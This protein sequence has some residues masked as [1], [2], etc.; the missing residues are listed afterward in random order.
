MTRASYTEGFNRLKQ[1]VRQIAFWVSIAV[2]VFRFGYGNGNYGSYDRWP[3]VT[4]F[5]RDD[6]VLLFI[7]CTLGISIFRRLCTFPIT[8]VEYV[9][10]GF[11]QFEPDE[12]SPSAR[13]LMNFYDRSTIWIQVIAYYTFWL[14]FLLI[15][16]LYADTDTARDFSIDT[17]LFGSEAATGY[18]VA[19]LIFV[20][21]RVFIFALQSL[22]TVG[23]EQWL[24]RQ[25]G[26]EVCDEVLD[27]IER[28]A[29]ARG[30][31]PLM[32]GISAWLPGNPIAAL[33]ASHAQHT[34]IDPSFGVGSTSDH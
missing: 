4:S 28:R 7:S 32:K 5:Y 18:A 33:R 9:L 10:A 30:Y 15:L 2:I 27:Y 17:R 13:I 8:A 31:L 29:A 12:L 34:R 19:L 1:V 25:F 14:L 22:V 6:A 23:V 11:L 16:W 24:H 20:L 26:Q 3:E 21:L